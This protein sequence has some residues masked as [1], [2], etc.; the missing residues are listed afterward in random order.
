M[1]LVAVSDL[2]L[3]QS[4]AGVD[5]FDDVKHVLDQAVE[6]A[7]EIKADAFAF[8]GDLTDPHTVRSHRSVDA[9]AEASAR[10][11]AHDVMVIMIAGN[12][13]VIED[14][15]G[16][17]VLDSLKHMDIGHVITEPCVREL[18][19]ES[20]VM[21][22]GKPR[23]IDL[24]TLIALPFTPTSHNYDPDAFI[25]SLTGDNRATGKVLV[26][27]HLNLEGITPG[28]E[29]TDMPRGRDV[30]WPLEALRELYPEAMLLGGHYHTPQVFEGVHIVGSAA[31]LRFD[32]A[33]NDP[34]FI[35]LEV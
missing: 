24:C 5:R 7:I 3:D 10:L 1:R 31:R 14:G 23:I 22:C 32:E 15:S 33:N 27:G 29:T 19:T 28:S 30:Y 12:H 13:D 4:T 25:R 16:R 26:I 21:V 2:H 20:P 18:V 17:T 8:C 9:L 34:G 6:H 11:K 35:V